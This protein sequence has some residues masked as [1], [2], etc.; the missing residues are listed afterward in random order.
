M[1]KLSFIK[2][3]PPSALEDQCDIDV[4]PI[5]SILIILIPFLVSMAVLTHLSILQFGL[6]PNVGPG[7]GGGGEKPKLKLTVVVTENYLGI[8]YGESMLDSIPAA[9]GVQN[10]DLFAQKLAARRQ[11]AGSDGNEIV[12]ASRDRIRLKDV[13]AVMDKCRE[14]GFEKIGL[15]SATDNPESGM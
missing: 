1:I 7:M 8:T 3:Q 2:N 9:G 15:S 11:A 13:V 6:P 14:T 12:V 5:M 4:T 10:F